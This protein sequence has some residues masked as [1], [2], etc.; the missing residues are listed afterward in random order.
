MDLTGIMEMKAVPYT[1][2]N[3][4]KERVF[5]TLVAEN[6]IANNHDHHI[7]YYLD[8]D[9]DDSGNSFINAKLQKERA[10][11]FGTPRTSYWTVVRET[12]KREA[13][14]RIRL[15][16]EPA[17][18]LIVNPNKRTNIGNQVGYRLISAQ[19]VTSLLSDDDYPQRR[20]SY[21]K[22]QVWVTPYNKSE[23]WAGGFYADRSRGD[24]GLAVWSHR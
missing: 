4:I 22:Y 6:T 21:T 8:L 7:T 18:L 12:A 14:A 15:G 23:R 16:L 10:T 3:Q 24:D 13:E 5:G 9:I 2:N 11:G 20:A 1:H 17:E 19:P